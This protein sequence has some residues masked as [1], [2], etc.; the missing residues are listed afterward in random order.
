[1]ISL[2]RFAVSPTEP[3]RRGRHRFTG[4]EERRR[5]RRGYAR[6][7][8]MT[9][10]VNDELLEKRR[11][12]LGVLETQELDAIVLRRPA[13]VAWYSGGGR[14]HIVATPEVGVADVVV[15]QDGDEVVT[16]V[17]EASRLEAEELGRLGASF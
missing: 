11:R 13:N 14:T 2:L 10:R 17:N 6:S 8:S 15:T 5:L 7:P 3:L 9:T 16:A 1:M 12:L 4:A